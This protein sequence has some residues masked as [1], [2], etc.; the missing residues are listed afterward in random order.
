MKCNVTSGWRD[1]TCFFPSK[2]QIL[3]IISQ[4]ILKSSL[5]LAND[6][7]VNDK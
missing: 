2:F 7:S 5:L 1:T 3:I 4:Y 6:V